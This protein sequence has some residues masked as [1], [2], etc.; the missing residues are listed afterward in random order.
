[1]LKTSVVFL[2]ASALALPAFSATDPFVGTWKLN[3]E[4]S[5]LKG[6]TQTI[7]SLGNNKYRF[8]FGTAVSF[9]ITTDG[10]DQTSLPGATMAI[11][12][13]DPN[14]WELVNKNNGTIVSTST[15][16]L[17]Q[18][19]KT[20]SSVEKGTRPDG[21]E[22]E[23]HASMKRV[24]GSGG[25]AGTWQMEDLKIGSPSLLQIETFGTNGLTVSFPADKVTMN[26]G[27]DGKETPVEGPTVLKGATVSAK[28]IN[29]RSIKVT[30]RLH[31]KQMDTS[32]WQVSSD[33][34]VLTMT[35]HDEGEKKPVVSVYDRQ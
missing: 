10:T 11:T 16:T 9:D 14:T 35:E 28:R 31:G 26:I 17:S 2:A 4:K 32:D 13:R 20:A 7:A 12:V 22:F 5:D 21:S 25:F 23:N 18:D 15:I 30:D 24:S 27:M 34:K 33:G 8:T 29:P 3:Q 19:G 6:Q 1:M